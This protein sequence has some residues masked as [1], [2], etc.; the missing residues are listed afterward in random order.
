MKRRTPLRSR[1]VPRRRK[2]PRWTADDWAHADGVLMRRC[3][4][5]CERCLTDVHPAYAHRHH[6]QRRRVGGDRLA[7]LLVLCQSCHTWIHDHPR[8][9]REHG[10]I[11]PASAP[12]PGAVPVLLHGRLRLLDDSGGS[13]PVAAG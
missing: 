12:D 3:G 6:R 4:G 9:A 5:R 13:I 10:W 2:A 8:N 1:P 7:N 11:V